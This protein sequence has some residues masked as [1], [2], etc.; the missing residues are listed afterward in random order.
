MIYDELRNYLIYVSSSETV[1]IFDSAVVVF[2]KYCV[3]NY[4]DLFDG[5]VSNN[6]THGPETILDCL[7]NDLR[8]ILTS[9]LT[10]QGVELKEDIMVSQLV[11]I[12]NAL[13]ELPYYFDKIIIKDIVSTDEPD[14]IKFCQLISLLTRYK[15]EEILSFLSHIDETFI[16]NFKQ[17]IKLIEDTSTT[18]DIK[19]HIGMYAKYKELVLRKE[20]SYCDKF[21]IRIQTIGLPYEDYI[22]QYMIDKKEYLHDSSAA[23]IE[24]VAKDLMGLTILSSDGLG[25][26]LMTIRKYLGNIYTDINISTKVDIAVSKILFKFT[27]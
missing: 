26:P 2:E 4:M 18:I 14:E 9:L 24:T 19:D 7:Y 8:L 6:N 27:G 11:D 16:D 15:T 1:D 3:P 20:N 23:Y 17:Q 5:T 21:F 25:N 22:N 12:V 10:I 13:F